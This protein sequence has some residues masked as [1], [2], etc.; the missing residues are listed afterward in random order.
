MPK[1]IFIGIHGRMQSGKDTLATELQKVIE[2]RD[3]RAVVH[4]AHFADNLKNSLHAFFGGRRENYFGSNQDKD[5]KV[6]GFEDVPHCGSYREL[7]QFMGTEIL[8][9]QFSF[10]IHVR[11]LLAKF[12][13]ISQ[14]IPRYVIVADVRFENER[15]AIANRGGPCIKIGRKDGLT[16]GSTHLSEQGLPDEAFDGSYNCAWGEHRD[17]AELVFDRHLRDIH[18]HE[19]HRG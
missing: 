2:A 13:P 15:Q 4:I 12:P 1:P 18:I 8:R 10:D 17:L 19:I 9:N 11:A 7:M 3:P 5:E 14:P 6:Q 16:T